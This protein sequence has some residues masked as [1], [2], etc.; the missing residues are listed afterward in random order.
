MTHTCSKIKNYK[1]RSFAIYNKSALNVG[2]LLVTAK[3]LKVLTDRYNVLQKYLSIFL[4][5]YTLP[6]LP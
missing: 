3:V 2:N 6:K 4:T 1:P 5:Y